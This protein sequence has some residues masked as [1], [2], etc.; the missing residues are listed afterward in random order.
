MKWV[1]LGSGSFQNL[2]NDL[3]AITNLCFL[4]IIGTWE[5]GNWVYSQIVV[6]IVRI[7]QKRQPYVLWHI[8]SRQKP[9]GFAISMYIPGFSSLFVLFLKFW[10]YYLCFVKWYFSF[11]LLILWL[12]GS[13]SQMKFVESILSNNTTDDHCQEFV[14]QKGLLPLV[15]ILGLPNLPIDF[16]TSAACQAVAGVCKSI[17]VRMHIFL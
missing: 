12:L 13:K 14:N 2:M 3:M 9:Y 11:P 1:N 6:I 7:W 16:P 15:S 17:L 5:L 10:L 4:K 8:I